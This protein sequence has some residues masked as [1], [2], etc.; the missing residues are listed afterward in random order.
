MDLRNVDLNLLMPLQ[1]LLEEKSVSRAAER[2]R[3]SQPSLSASLARLRKLFDDE[4]LIRRGNTYELSPLAVSLRERTWRAVT[5]LDRVFS[6]QVQFDPA[7]S[8]REFRLRGTDYSF[9]LIGSAL[10]AAISQV[11]PGVTLRFDPLDGSTVEHAPASLR[12]C[13]G[14]VIP[15][16]F[17]NSDRYLELFSDRWV[18]LVSSDNEEVGESVLIDDLSGL[19]WVYTL[20]DSAAFTPAARQMQMHGVEPRVE[21]VTP[22]FMALPELIEGTRRIGL[23]QQRL[24]ER[25]LLGRRLRWLP[26]P[27][28]VAPLK[29]AFWWNEL[30]DHDPEHMWLRS[31]LLQAGRT[32]AETPLAS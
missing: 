18:L 4:L 15:H 7:T 21:A 9:A 16:G 3:M 11:A 22:N 29:E 12:D 8:R 20:N 6:T 14:A 17:L 5:S 10:S 1:A 27:F 25:V 28:E 2:L 30:Y 24:A 13:D 19:P 31:M 23:I 26:C 32:I